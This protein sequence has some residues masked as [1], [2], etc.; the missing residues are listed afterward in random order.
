LR[1]LTA[2][3]AREKQIEDELRSKQKEVGFKDENDELVEKYETLRKVYKKWKN[4]TKV[5]EHNYDQKVSFVDKDCKALE[6]KIRTLS[7]R[8]EALNKVLQE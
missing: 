5:T 7:E 3:L 6:I 8:S 1:E 4:F 2:E